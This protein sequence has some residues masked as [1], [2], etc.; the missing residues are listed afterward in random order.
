MLRS[1]PGSARQLFEKNGSTNFYSYSGRAGIFWISAAETENP[2]LSI[3]LAA[4]LR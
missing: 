4:A 1:S 3:L 2:L